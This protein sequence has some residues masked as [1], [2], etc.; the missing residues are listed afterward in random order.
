MK[1]Y[2]AP[3]TVSVAVCVALHEAGQPHDLIKVDF[4][5]SEQTGTAYLGINAKGRVPALETNGTVLT[6][7]GALLDYIAA[8][9]PNA[10]LM[11]SDPVEAARV[12][13]VMYYL[14]STMHINH[15]HKM[16]GQR[17]ATEQSSLD[18]MKAKVTEN[19]TASAAFVE[20]E[21]LAG[22]F[23]LGDVISIADCYPYAVCNWLD[24]D[25]VDVAAF[26]KISTFLQTMEQRDSVKASRAKGVI[27]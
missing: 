19:M 17:W 10:G 15:A 2:F 14:A 7:T 9:H 24:G 6:E 12:R 4:A 25:G 20:D 18:D 3:N 8:L 1:L 5:A 27:V 21:C 26:P 22:P 23:V 16:R 11:P 13:S